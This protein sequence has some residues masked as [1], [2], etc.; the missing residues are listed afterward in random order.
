MESFEPNI[1]DQRKHPLVLQGDA[2]NRK[3]TIE[4]VVAD[5]E[6]KKVIGKA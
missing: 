4:H 6:G 1:V 5:S 2:G 3:E